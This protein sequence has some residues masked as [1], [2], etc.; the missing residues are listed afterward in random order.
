[1]Q[2]IDIKTNSNRFKLRVSGIFIR[3]GKV[4][5]QKCK[6]IDGY[7]FPGG[8]VE[9]GEITKEAVLRE[10][11]E[12]IGI[13]VKIIDLFCVHENIY[14][15]IDNNIAQEIN[16]YYLLD[17]KEIIPFD[18]FET[19]END[20]GTLKV[21]NYEWLKINELIDKKVN[22]LSIAN[23]IIKGSNRNNILLTDERK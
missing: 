7:C 9:L 11:K 10:I 8:H 16:Y 15:T 12:E 18:E 5:V 2:D 23:L 22:P 4:L 14:K 1:M 17:S 3:D 13:E 20:K 19:T 6:K 21:H